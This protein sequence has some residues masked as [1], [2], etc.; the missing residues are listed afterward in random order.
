M[1]LT[2]INKQ[3]IYNL[4][5]LSI[6]DEIKNIDVIVTSPPYNIGI[7]YSI[8]K[9]KLSEENYLDWLSI[10]FEKLKNSLKDDGSFFLNVGSTLNNPWI[11][12]DVANIA[13]NIFYLQ[14][15]IIWVKSISIADKSYGHFKPINSERFM[16]H[17]FEHVF[18]FTKNNKIKIDKLSIGV[19][20]ADKSNIKRWEHEQDKR[21]RGNVWFVPYQTIKN[22]QK[23]KSGHP[24]IFPL[25]LVEQ[26]IKL[27]GISKNMSVLDPFMGQG[28]TLMVCE[29]LDIKGIGIEI[30]ENY[31]LSACE[32]I[33][34]VKILNEI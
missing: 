4:D 13:R 14:N 26:C 3:T 17:N 22:R 23:D 30:D 31:Y 34:K 29:Q 6:L 2:Q 18:H 15:H 12:L 1:E 25:K 7:K 5:C 20:Y 32:N 11:A 28:T 10:V 27:H 16:N 33:R 9:D 19:P 24:A 21:D 8:Y